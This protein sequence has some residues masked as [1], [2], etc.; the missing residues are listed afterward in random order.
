MKKGTVKRICEYIF[1]GVIIAFVLTLLLWFLYYFKIFDMPDFINDFFSGKSENVDSSYYD[2]SAFYTYLS[3]EN[4]TV[5]TTEPLELT[6]GNVSELI[7]TLVLK[8]NFY[9][10]VEVSYFYSDKS[11]TFNHKWWSHEGK[12][13]VDSSGK[14]IDTSTVFDGE[15]TVVRNNISGETTSFAAAEDTVGV[16]VISVADVRFYLESDLSEIKT[17][18]LVSTESER[19]LLVTFYTSELDKTDLFYISLNSGAV[20][21]VESKIK[22]VT[23]FYQKTL[24]F[25]KLNTLSES[26][27]KI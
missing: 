13:R 9:W 16:D 7:E 18:D 14:Y 25:Y 19:Y 1:S 22:D 4:E 8:D 27:F 15:K 23:V 12:I 24:D 26:Y 11:E 3:S 21:F 2:E 17:A 5:L 10:D 20:L 6:T